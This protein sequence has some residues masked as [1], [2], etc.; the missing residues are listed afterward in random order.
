M[1]NNSHKDVS[2]LMFSKRMLS[3]W[4]SWT[5]TYEPDLCCFMIPRKKESMFFSRK[6]SKTEESFWSPQI[7]ISEIL[8]RLSTNK[9]LFDSVTVWFLV[10]TLCKYFN[11]SSEW[12]FLLEPWLCH[13]NQEV[14]GECCFRNMVFRK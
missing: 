14:E 13:G 9:V 4:R 8:R 7:R 6:K 5:Q 3:V 1:I 10:M 12:G 11:S 2:F